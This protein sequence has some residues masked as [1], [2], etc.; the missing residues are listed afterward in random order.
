ME[1]TANPKSWNALGHN[2]KRSLCYMKPIINISY[3]HLERPFLSWICCN[4]KLIICFQRLCISTMSIK[5]HWN[6][7]WRLEITNS[8][9][10]TH[11][12]GKKFSKGHRM[13]GPFQWKIVKC[14]NRE[15]TFESL[16]PH[17]HAIFKKKS[18]GG[19]FV[20]II[21]LLLYGGPFPCILSTR[22]DITFRCF[23]ALEVSANC[24]VTQI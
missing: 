9:S 8:S 22:F 10:Y 18:S 1:E 3:S 5:A 4:S 12:P 17:N 13:D 20:N 23:A 6:A 16:T 2:F 15:Y 19:F 11:L 14:L 24:K 21:T 7:Y